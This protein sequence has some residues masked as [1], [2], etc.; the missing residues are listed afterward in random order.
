MSRSTERVRRCLLALVTAMLAHQAAPA[1]LAQ[2]PAR[3]LTI[4]V[5][6]SDS[7]SRPVSGAQ[8][9]VRGAGDSALAV[10][11]AGSEGRLVL[12]VQRGAG[13]LEVIARRIGF[14]LARHA[15]PPGG[16]D[17]VSLSIVM[18]HHTERLEAVNVTAGRLPTNGTLIDAD[19]IANSPRPLANGL[20]VLLKV[21]P[22]MI[23]WLNGRRGCEGR[24]WVYVNGVHVQQVPSDFMTDAKLAEK[25]SATVPGTSGVP[26]AGPPISAAVLGVDRDAINTLATIL[27][28]QIATISVSDCHDAPRPEMRIALKPGLRFD[29]GRGV[30]AITEEAQDSIVRKLV[31][32]GALR[33]RPAPGQLLGVYDPDSGE[34][35]ADADVI[36]VASGRWTRTSESGTASLAFVAERPALLAV[37]KAGYR[38]DSVRVTA[39]QPRDVPITQLLHRADPPAAPAAPAKP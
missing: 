30:L 14:D 24:T 34:P 7:A 28:D 20:D 11:V 26:R 39:A 18:V 19:A 12:R 25:T 21:Q 17:S 37:L 33:A 36:D 9:V 38:P 32:P 22:A 15:I 31:R 35:I 5:R 1:A 23:D 10:G 13:A 8:V 16:A 2:A 4:A 6:V 29:P 3:P 27:P